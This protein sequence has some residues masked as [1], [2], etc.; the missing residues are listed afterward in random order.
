MNARFEA[1]RVHPIAHTLRASV[2]ANRRSAFT[3]GARRNANLN[4]EEELGI[5]LPRLFRNPAA[6]ISATMI[7][8]PTWANGF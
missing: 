1:A 4:A 6:G 7:G 8:K 5:G 3:I 2:N